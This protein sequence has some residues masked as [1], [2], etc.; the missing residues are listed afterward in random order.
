MTSPVLAAVSTTA[1][2]RPSIVRTVAGMT[3]PV[4]RMIRGTWNLSQPILHFASNYGY[5][6]PPHR[7][8]SRKADR[9]HWL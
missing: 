1:A 5:Y 7:D 8:S 2:A 6:G 4:R 3:E 9:S